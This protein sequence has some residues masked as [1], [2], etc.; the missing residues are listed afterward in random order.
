MK[1]RSMPAKALADRL[2]H[3]RV[4]PDR[5]V[6]VK[7]READKELRNWRSNQEDQP[8]KARPL[9]LMVTSLL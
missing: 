6:E 2:F 1:R 4:V 8:D 3:Q 5:R 9:P 7:E